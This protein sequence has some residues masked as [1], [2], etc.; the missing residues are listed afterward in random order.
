MLIWIAMI[1][2]GAGIPVSMRTGMCRWICLE[3][4]VCMHIGITALVDL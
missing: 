4:P 3:N 2:F 1:V